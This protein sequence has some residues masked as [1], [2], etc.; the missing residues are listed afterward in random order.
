MASISEIANTHSKHYTVVLAIKL[1]LGGLVI[2]TIVKN[3]INNNSNINSLKLIKLNEKIVIWYPVAASKV[4]VY[5]DLITI[6]EARH[7]W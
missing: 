2:E 3:T 6:W 4:P 1:K 5:K 7:S